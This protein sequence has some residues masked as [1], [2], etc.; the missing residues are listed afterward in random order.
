MLSEN[1]PSI[2]SYYNVTAGN[3]IMYIAVTKLH[4]NAK[5]VKC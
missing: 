2:Y 3:C 5:E 1:K 4:V